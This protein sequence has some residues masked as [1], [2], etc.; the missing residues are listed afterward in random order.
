V[1]ELYKLRIKVILFLMWDI[2]NYLGIRIKTQ[3]K[4]KV[5]IIR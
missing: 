1:Y 5:C 3:L 2:E 4:T